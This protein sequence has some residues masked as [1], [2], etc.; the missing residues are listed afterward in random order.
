MESLMDRNGVYCRLC[1]AS[2]HLNLNVRK[3]YVNR[4]FVSIVNRK[5]KFLS[6]FAHLRRETDTNQQSH[7]CVYS[8]ITKTSANDMANGIVCGGNER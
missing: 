8:S 3:M 5:S 2:K 1:A 4:R 7:D 6:A